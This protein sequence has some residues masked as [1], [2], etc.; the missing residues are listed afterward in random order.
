VSSRL[1]DQPD[2]PVP[3]PSDPTDGLVLLRRLR[4]VG[5]VAPVLFLLVLQLLRAFVFQPRWPEHSY[6]GV[7]I[8]GVLGAA[9]FG[10]VMFLLIDRAYQRLLTQQEASADDR[11]TSAVLLERDRIAREMHDS[12]AQVLGVLHLRLRSLGTLPDVSATAREELDDLADLSQEAYRDVREAIL[13]L[14]ES[15]R[16]DRTLLESLGAYVEKFS[17][18]SQ[19]STTLDASL[20]G[21]LRLS[22][23]CEVQVIRVIQEALTNVRKHSGARS[24]R[25]QV[26]TTPAQTRFV[27]EDD[28]R[29]FDPAALPKDRQGFGLHTMRERTEQV[30][31]RLTIDSEPGR[32]TR[33]VVE[34]PRAEDDEAVA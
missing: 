14:R 19:I 29:G 31:G 24:A 25:V 20:D 15:S 23:E 13:G 34:L 5:I 17:R 11:Q 7:G 8:V 26:D 16:G 12:L 6:I 1:G 22:P 3:S 4:F 27:V 32:G 28:G 21:D 30:Q 9:V 10:M 18:Q 33:V 2:T